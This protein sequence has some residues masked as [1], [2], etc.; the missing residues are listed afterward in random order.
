MLTSI[1]Q[2][3]Y[4]LIAPEPLQLDDSG[5]GI[6]DIEQE[7][8]TNPLLTPKPLNAPLRFTDSPPLM[9]KEPTGY[10]IATNEA[11]EEVILEV[12]VNDK[13][14]HTIEVNSDKEKEHYYI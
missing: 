6:S 14:S 9:V 3:F 13:F 12:S 2:N 11:N 4:E 5:L 10:V 7:S 8:N 1:L